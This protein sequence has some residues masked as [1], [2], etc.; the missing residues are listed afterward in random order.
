[1]PNLK[2]ATPNL[3][4]GV[5]QIRNSLVDTTVEKM[6]SI[7]ASGRAA[8]GPLLACLKDTEVDSR[9]GTGEKTMK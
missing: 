5:E 2:D 1:M 3:A 9:K 4:E 7:A 8:V 6:V